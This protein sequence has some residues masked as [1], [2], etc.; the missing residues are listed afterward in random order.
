MPSTIL[1]AWFQL[2]FADPPYHAAYA[3]P[4][5]YHS[6]PLRRCYQFSRTL[7]RAEQRLTSQQSRPLGRCLGFNTR[8]SRNLNFTSHTKW[9]GKY[10]TRPGLREP[11]TSVLLGYI[12]TH[13]ARNLRIL[14][15]QTWTDLAD[16]WNP[17]VYPDPSRKFRVCTS[18][19]KELAGLT[20]YGKLSWYR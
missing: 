5:W 1:E 6:S 19:E 10:V 2:T 12:L 14:W 20:L 9:T 17:V 4:N 16:R 18:C 15:T 7:A 11:Q 3:L 13:N 8:Q